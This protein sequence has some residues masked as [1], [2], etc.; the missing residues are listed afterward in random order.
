[1]RTILSRSALPPVSKKEER[2][3][4]DKIQNGTDEEKGPAEELLL[5]SNLKLIF[6]IA[7]EFKDKGVPVEDLVSEGSR[8][9][10]Y[11]MTKFDLSKDVRFIS[12][13]AFWIR[14]KMRL[15][16]EKQG[17]VVT[18]PAEAL[19]KKAKVLNTKT[20][21]AKELGREPTVKELSKYLKIPE[22]KIRIRLY[23]LGLDVRIDEEENEETITNHIDLSSVDNTWEQKEEEEQLKLLETCITKLPERSQYILRMRFGYTGKEATLEEVGQEIGCCRE[24]VRQL[25]TDALNRLKKIVDL[26]E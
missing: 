3:L 4:L 23:S 2:T 21:L 1:M 16:V 26:L 20:R 6:K 24:R 12:Y 8:G 5:R 18:I 22:D 9:L 7:D 15:A 14:Q 17:R 19:I 11:A 13:A 10:L 25:Q